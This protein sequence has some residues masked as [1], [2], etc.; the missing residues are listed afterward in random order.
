MRVV[1]L[2]WYTTFEVRRPCHLEDMADDETG[3]RVTSEVGNLHS[4][5]WHA[6]PSG[7]RIICYVRD[8]RTDGQRKPTLNAPSLRA[9]A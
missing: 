3:M 9:R 6:R 1:V 2:H 4:E 8:G 7:S 5:F